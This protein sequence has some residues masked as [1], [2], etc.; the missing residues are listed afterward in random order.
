MSIDEQARVAENIRLMRES[1]NMT[2][3]ELAEQMGL[4]DKS[5]IS[6]IE[7]GKMPITLKTVERIAKVFKCAP[8][9]LMGWTEEMEDRMIHDFMSVMVKGNPQSVFDPETPQYQYYFKNN[10]ALLAEQVFQDKNLRALFDAAREADPEDIKLAT[11][12]LTRFK[13]TNP[14][15]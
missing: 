14:D 13:R 5:S 11:E 8:R 3:A 10:T 7:S 15:G 9:R 2:Q 1:L 12:M 4:K 6:K